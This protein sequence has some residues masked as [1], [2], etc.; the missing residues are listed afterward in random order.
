MRPTSSSSSLSLSR[1]RQAA[2][3][4]SS[5]RRARW[6]GRDRRRAAE[7]IESR[8]RSSLSLFGAVGRAEQGEGWRILTGGLQRGADEV[9]G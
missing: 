2:G 9:G 5:P 3:D 4:E 7:D 1:L 6:G 8:R